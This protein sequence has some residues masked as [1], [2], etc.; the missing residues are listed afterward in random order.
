MRIKAWMRGGKERR[1]TVIEI[2]PKEA[3]AGHL[4]ARNPADLEAWLEKY[5]FQW[6]ECQFGWGWSGG[7]FEND[8]SCMEGPGGAGLCVVSE[9]AVPNT[10]RSRGSRA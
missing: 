1:E 2:P 10:I 7:G 4:S 8:F 3:R 9:S 5:V 6:I